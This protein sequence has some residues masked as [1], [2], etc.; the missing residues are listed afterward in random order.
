M[1]RFQGGDRAAFATLVRRHKTPIY[2]FALRMVRS[3]SAAEDLTQD[4][5]V[6]VVQSGGEFKHE[7]RFYTWVYSIVRNLCID[8]LRKMSLRQHPSLDQ[9]SAL[10]PEGPALAERMAG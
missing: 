8:H 4:T 7:A 1:V 2:N 3:S 9:P 10:A 6:K 5:F